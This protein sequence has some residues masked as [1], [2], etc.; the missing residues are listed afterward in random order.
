MSCISRNMESAVIYCFLPATTSTI[1][2]IAEKSNPRQSATPT[3]AVPML[4]SPQNAKNAVRM[5]A[6]AMKMLALIDTLRRTIL[7]NTPLSETISL[8]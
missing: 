7:S 3:A 1:Y 6:T 5:S 4:P 8:G 2:P